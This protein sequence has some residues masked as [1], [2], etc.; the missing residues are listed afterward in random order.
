[1]KRGWKGR[2]KGI[3]PS[4]VKVSRIN[5]APWHMRPTVT[6]TEETVVRVPLGHC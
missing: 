6:D 3:P 2:G 5:T 4:K 1:V